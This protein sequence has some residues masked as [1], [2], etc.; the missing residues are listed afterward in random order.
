MMSWIKKRRKMKMRKI[1]KGGEIMKG[2]GAR[3]E[4]RTMTMIDGE[5]CIVWCLRRKLFIVSAGMVSVFMGPVWG[6]R[7]WKERIGWWC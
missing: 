7:S 6:V 3:R 2:T 1:R 4:M 5:L